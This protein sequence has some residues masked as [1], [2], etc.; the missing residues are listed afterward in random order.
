MGAIWSES[1]PGSAKQG[2]SRLTAAILSFG[3]HRYGT[4]LLSILFIELC[5]GT[6]VAGQEADYKKVRALCNDRQE[7][8]GRLSSLLMGR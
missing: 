4:I 7:Q 8:Q 6:S 2:D 3:R 1:I 5:L